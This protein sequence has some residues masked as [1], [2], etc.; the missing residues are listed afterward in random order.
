MA[1]IRY[2]TLADFSNP[3]REMDRLKRDMD[4]IFSDVMGRGP[5]GIGSG[6]F[7]ALNVF[8]VS[9]KIVVQAELPG[10]KAEDIEISV[11]RETL[12]LRGERKPEEMQNVSYHRRERRTGKFQ[13]SLTLPYEINVDGVEANFKDGVLK[14]ILLKAEYVKP[15]KISIKA[16]QS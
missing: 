2:P 6:V 11:E 5:L 10:F 16:Q 15:K 9:D 3:F 4:R 14:L 13:K 12:S 1:I 7:P 8:E